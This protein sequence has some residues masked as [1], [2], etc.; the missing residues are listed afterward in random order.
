ML[1]CLAHCC[2][3]NISV[4]IKVILQ[5]LLTLTILTWL[6]SN[7]AIHKEENVHMVFVALMQP[8]WDVRPAQ[9]EL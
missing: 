5:E 8:Y 2:Q 1:N 7:T 9:H 4:F 6:L 3:Y